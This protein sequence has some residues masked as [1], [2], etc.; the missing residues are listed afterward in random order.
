MADAGE[1]K[2]CLTMSGR[3]LFYI[4]GGSFLF[5]IPMQVLGLSDES[6]DIKVYL[7]AAG[8]AGL[9]YLMA[10]GDLGLESGKSNKK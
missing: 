10:G 1:Q 4:A 8:F 3:L 5:M 6:Y 9:G 2:G 7:I